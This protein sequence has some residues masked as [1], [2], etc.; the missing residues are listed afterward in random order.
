MERRRRWKRKRGGEREGHGL[1]IRWMG[2]SSG[3]CRNSQR[4][5]HDRGAFED[6]YIVVPLK[7]WNKKQSEGARPAR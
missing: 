3:G 5:I 1:D 2:A 6:M 4:G 7:L